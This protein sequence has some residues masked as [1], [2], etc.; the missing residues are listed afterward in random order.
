[1]IVVSNPLK[2]IHSEVL[3]LVQNLVIIVDEAAHMVGMSKTMS[4]CIH[5]GVY[6]A[7]NQG[8]KAE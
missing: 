8:K 2:C 4:I 5:Y 3:E 1:M 7:C 6:M